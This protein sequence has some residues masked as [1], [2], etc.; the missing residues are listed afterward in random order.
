MED[1]E[2]EKTMVD[3]HPASQCE[4]PGSGAQLSHSRDI[5]SFKDLSVED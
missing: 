3:E 2:G 4:Q 1:G 5:V